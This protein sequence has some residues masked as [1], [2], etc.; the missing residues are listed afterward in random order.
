MRYGY[1]RVST[2]EQAD[3]GTGLDVQRAA[4]RA[5]GRV[6]EW[7]TDA[8]ESGSHGLEIRVGLAQAL[9]QLDDGDQLVVYRLDRLARDL[10]LQET[11]IQQ[12]RKAG[13]QLVSCSESEN[14]LLEDEDS[15]PSRRLIRQILG[16]VAEY[17][18][19]IIRMRMRAGKIARKARG[20]WSSG[21]AP[22]GYKINAEKR[23]EPIP[24]EQQT[25]GLML[26][27]R[28]QG[29]S[30]Q[31]VADH[32]NAY[33]ITTRTG[34]RWGAKTVYRAVRTAQGTVPN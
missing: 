16:A 32:L 4:I 25:V 13:G 8:G 7:F 9:D 24:D 23:L 22:Y 18:R 1:L 5:T 20:F 33:G 19:A 28:H 14:R 17:E 15:D 2:R 30:Y 26:R 3:N 11:L 34:A 12:I 6:H 27:Y 31:L 29:F 10:I 21:P